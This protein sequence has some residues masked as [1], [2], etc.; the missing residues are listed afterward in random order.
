MLRTS[1]KNRIRI[2]DRLAVIAATALA[3]SAIAGMTP[4]QVGKSLNEMT[5]VA[6]QWA[7][8]PATGSSKGFRSSLFLFRFR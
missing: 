7:S 8:Q 6:V 4:E 5:Q 2:P 3:I 1:L